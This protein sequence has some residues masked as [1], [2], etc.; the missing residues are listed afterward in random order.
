[1]TTTTEQSITLSVAASARADRWVP[2]RAGLVSVW[3]YVRK[4][5]ATGASAAAWAER[6]ASRWRSSSL[7]FS[8]TPTCPTGSR[9]RRNPEG[10]VRPNLTGTD[11]PSR[12]GF[13]WVEFERGDAV[14]TIGEL[15]IPVDPT[16][17][18]TTSRPPLGS[19]PTELLDDQRASVAKGPEGGTRRQRTGHGTLTY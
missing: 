8:S 18:S 4:P 1:M 3:R 13:V 10:L 5:S 15:R 7:P 14:F 19:A 16:V 2:S 17:V 11:E 12:T 6:R 9:R